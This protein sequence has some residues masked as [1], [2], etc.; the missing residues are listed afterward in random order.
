LLD[1]GVDELARQAELVALLRQSEITLELL[2]RLEAI[3]DP[4]P[5]LAI[6]RCQA[7]RSLRLTESGMRLLQKCNPPTPCDDES[8]RLYVRIQGEIALCTSKCNYDKAFELFAGA[9]RSSRDLLGPTHKT[10]TLLLLDYADFLED[11]WHF[12]GA[13]DVLCALKL[14]SEDLSQSLRE[15]ILQEVKRLRHRRAKNRRRERPMP[16]GHSLIEDDKENMHQSEPHSPC[17][18]RKFENDKEIMHQSEPHSP[19][20]ERR[21]CGEPEHESR[22]GDATRVD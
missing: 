2:K 6:I 19:S 16:V 21:L 22:E 12:S 11:S 5:S 17:K 10:T 9:I 13:L 7:F 1:S 14:D 4:T 15:H 18:K 8:R 3:A 20:K